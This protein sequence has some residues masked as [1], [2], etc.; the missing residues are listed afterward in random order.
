MVIIFVFLTSFF[1]QV[2]EMSNCDGDAGT[3]IHAHGA[4]TGGSVSST[5]V[6][7]CY[8]P[9]VSFCVHST[10][11]WFLCVTDKWVASL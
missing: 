1:V 3:L 7:R 10:V 2:S 5:V 8:N 9:C 11:H 4:H 6:S